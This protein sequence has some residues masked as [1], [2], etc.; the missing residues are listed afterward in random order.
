MVEHP[1]LSAYDAH[2]FERPVSR[3][4]EHPMEA[5]S[6]PAAVPLGEGGD[7]NEQKASNEARGSGG[8]TDTHPRG[9]SYSL[10]EK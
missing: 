6:R 7:G 9:G 5:T 10:G 8:T 3:V 1:Y 4:G 2:D